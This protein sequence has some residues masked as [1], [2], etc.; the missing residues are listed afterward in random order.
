M[1]RYIIDRDYFNRNLD[2]LPENL[3]VVVGWDEP[4][5]TFFAIVEDFSREETDEQDTVL[6]WLGTTYDEIKDI[7]ELQRLLA[8]YATVPDDIVRQCQQDSGQPFNPSPL[9]RQV[10]SWFDGVS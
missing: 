1:S 5:R 7:S 10:E 9:Q 6:L 4:L 8:P 3:E 2:S